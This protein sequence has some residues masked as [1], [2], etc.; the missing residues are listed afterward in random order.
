LSI[1]KP[2]L[3]ANMPIN[4]LDNCSLICSIVINRYRLT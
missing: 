4:R 3:A 2:L 1:A